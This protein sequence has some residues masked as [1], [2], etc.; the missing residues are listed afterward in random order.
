VVVTRPAIAERS[1]L[2]SNQSI[3]HGPGL[4]RKE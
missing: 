4:G 1:L 3:S 2:E